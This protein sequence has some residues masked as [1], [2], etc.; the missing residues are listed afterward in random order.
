M[1]W[2]LFGSGRS[3]APSYQNVT[4]I[5]SLLLVAGLLAAC[6]PPADRAATQGDGSVTIV[7]ELLQPPAIGPAPLVVTLTDPEGVGI[8]GAT[9]RVEGDMTHAGMVPVL[10]DAVGQ[11]EGVYHADDMRFTMAGDW[12]I[13]I[14]VTVDGKRSSGVLL[15]NV[16]AR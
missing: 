4:S 6:K 1:C 5:L 15:V 7:S 8:D 2:R 10:V 3:P 16:P 13:T 11:G 14:T 12:I 9:V